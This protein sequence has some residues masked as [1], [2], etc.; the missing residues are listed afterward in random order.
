MRAW[1]NLEVDVK[2]VIDNLNREQSE[3]IIKYIDSEK[4]DWDFTLD[5]CRY[6]LGEV[7]EEFE[8]A[9]GEGFDLITTKDIFEKDW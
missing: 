2:E 8:A 4:A 7:K 9:G 1:C 5:M 3:E 6:F